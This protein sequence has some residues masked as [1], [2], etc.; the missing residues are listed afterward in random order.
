VLILDE[1]GD[2]TDAQL[3]E[4]KGSLLIDFQLNDNGDLELQQFGEDLGMNSSG[5]KSDHR[6][7]VSPLRSVTR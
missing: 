6:Q 1:F 4:A 7:F 2:A 3:F 5:I